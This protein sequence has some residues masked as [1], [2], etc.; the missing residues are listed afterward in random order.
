MNALPHRDDGCVGVPPTTDKEEPVS[1]APSELFTDTGYLTVSAGT[2]NRAYPLPGAQIEIYLPNDS[3]GDSLYRRLETD[4]SGTAPKILIPTPQTD[5]SLTPD[6]AWFPYS[7]ARVRI[8]CNGYYPVEAR[9]VPVF[10]GITSLQ[11]FDMIPTAEGEAYR[12]S[13]GDLIITSEHAAQTP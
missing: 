1:H 4:A 2:G 13:S 3:G 5:L 6:S 7:L 9:E 10:P 8:F 11:Y 12:E